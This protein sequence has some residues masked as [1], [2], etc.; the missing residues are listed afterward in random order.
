MPLCP[1]GKLVNINVSSLSPCAE[2]A[3]ERMSEAMADMQLQLE[4]RDLDIRPLR[5]ALQR[6]EAAAAA[7][8][9]AVGSPSHS[10]PRPQALLASAGCGGGGGGPKHQR[11]MS[12][13]GYL[14][15]LAAGRQLSAQGPHQQRQQQQQQQQYQSCMP[16]TSLIA[17]RWGD[18]ASGPFWLEFPGPGGSATLRGGGAAATGGG[19]TR[20]GSFLSASDGSTTD[21]LASSLADCGG[22]LL[23]AAS[24]RPN[25]DAW[26]AGGG[27]G[28]IFGAGGSTGMLP[29]LLGGGSALSP[30]LVLRPGILGGGGGGATDA[31]PS[32]ASMLHDLPVCFV[33]VPV[34]CHRWPPALRTWL[35]KPR[36]MLV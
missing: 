35:P 30:A 29:G 6:A 23:P 8:A 3:H 36:G 14:P 9:R 28:G 1:R 7:A 13:G 20:A 21:S 32:F 34:S 22:V 19:A 15:H 12:L 18:A 33:A 16:L 11:S 2:S 4:G 27:G 26:F 25:G 24:P 10:R 5:L 17:Q 31:Q